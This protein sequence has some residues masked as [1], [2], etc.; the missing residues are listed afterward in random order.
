MQWICSKW[1]TQWSQ[2]VPPMSTIHDSDVRRWTWLMTCL[3]YIVWS[4]SSLSFC[5][6]SCIP[7]C[8]LNNFECLIYKILSAIFKLYLQPQVTYQAKC[9][10]LSIITLYSVS[11]DE[12]WNILTYLL[13][14]CTICVVLGD[15]SKKGNHFFLC[16]LIDYIKIHFLLSFIWIPLFI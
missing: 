3:V 15:N 11:I 16:Y 1:V 13:N 7:F 8:L 14:A 5:C 2:H 10:V 9:L 4:S 6:I 12:S